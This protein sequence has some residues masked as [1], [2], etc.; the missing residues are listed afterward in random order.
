MDA[1]QPLR[2]FL[3]DDS[4]AIRQRVAVLLAG[5]EMA[6]VGEGETP[7]ACIAGILGAQPD[8]VVLDAQLDGGTGLD[9]LRAVRG[10]A[11]GIAFIVFTNNAG[12]AYRKRYLAEGAVGFLDKSGEFDQLAGAVVRACRTH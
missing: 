2:V 4:A 10:A 3:A 9:V 12:P 7:A 5:S 11:P 8:V 6:I 1:S